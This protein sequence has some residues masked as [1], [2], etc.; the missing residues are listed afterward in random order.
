MRAGKLDQTIEIRRQA[1]DA[2]DE[3]GNVI[4]GSVTTVATLRAQIIQASTEE[5][6]RGWGASDATAIIFRTRHMDGITLSDIVRHG[7]VDF[8][9]KEIKPIGRRRGLELRAVAT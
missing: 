7:G 8:N 2:V 4:P 6:I 1:N 3:F 5:F 9:L